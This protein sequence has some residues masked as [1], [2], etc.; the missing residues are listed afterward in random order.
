MFAQSSELKN[1]WSITRAE[2]DSR[3]K[4]VHIYIS[5]SKTAKYPCPECG[6]QSSKYNEERM[7][8]YGVTQMWFYILAMY[9]A[10]AHR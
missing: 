9:N 10:N 7:S 2:F 5:G 6:A 8:E 4:A 1:P 3:E